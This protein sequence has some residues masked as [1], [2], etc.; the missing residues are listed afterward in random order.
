MDKLIALLKKLP[1]AVRLLLPMPVLPQKR[2]MLLMFVGIA[3]LI[4]NIYVKQTPSPEDDKILDEVHQIAL[5]LLAQN[6]PALV[7]Q[8]EQPEQSF[9]ETS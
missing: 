6:Q 9:G 8:G 1:P 7:I 5:Q 3:Y 4:G 2:Y